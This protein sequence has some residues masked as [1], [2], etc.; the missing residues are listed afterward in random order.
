VKRPIHAAPIGT[1]WPPG[2]QL[3]NPYVDWL[4][5]AATH[6][7]FAAAVLVELC[8][9]SVH[10]HESV[11]IA[12][13]GELELRGGVQGSRCTG[14]NSHAEVKATSEE[15]L[16]CKRYEANATP[17][18]WFSLFAGHHSNVHAH[19]PRSTRCVALNNNNRILCGIYLR[20]EWCGMEE[21]N[22][23]GA[24][25]VVGL[26]EVAVAHFIRVRHHEEIEEDRPGYY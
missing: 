20:E 16:S 18:P 22:H 15:C 5:H 19:P 13:E 1:R 6:E 10:S 4:T 2:S 3:L 23:L 17:C 9:Q 12:F 8:E 7:E 14:F 26:C 24:D 25:Q 21:L 11:V